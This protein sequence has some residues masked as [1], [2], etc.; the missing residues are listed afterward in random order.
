[1][2]QLL[3]SASTTGQNETPLQEIWRGIRNWEFWTTLAWVDIK[4]RYRRT[5]LGPFWSALNSLIFVTILA[6]VYSVLWKTELKN[7]LPF[8]AAGYFVWNFFAVCIGESCSIFHAHGET[9][10]TMPVPPMALLVRVLARNF[11]V[12]LHNL[13]IFFGI[14]L[15]LGLPVWGILLALPGVV[16]V[17]LTCMGFGTALAFLCSRF[18]DFEQIIQSVLQV[19]FFVSPILWQE[20]SLPE[21]A[22]WLADYNLVYHLLRVARDPLLGIVPPLSSVLIAVATMMAALTLG[23]VVY[24]NFR[25]RLTYWL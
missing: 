9:L 3:K 7:F 8:V 17:G 4:G 22:K 5:M 12:F 20:K 13:L 16:I 25:R 10:K 6:T 23:A 18:R 15:I 1:M 14:A 11:I 24:H 19:V 21:N 2:S